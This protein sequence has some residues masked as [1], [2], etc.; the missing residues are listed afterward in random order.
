MKTFMKILLFPVMA[1][2]KTASVIIEILA[3]ISAI[4]AG[5]FLVFVTGCGIYCTVT[6]N[7]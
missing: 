3:K 6:T 7:F 5:P 1:V 2:L 4:L